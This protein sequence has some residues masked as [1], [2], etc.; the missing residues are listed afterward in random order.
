VAFGFD[1]ADFSEDLVFL[2]NPSALP[3]LI[4]GNFYKDHRD[5][6]TYPTA[7]SLLPFSLHP[8]TQAVLLL[9]DKRL[10]P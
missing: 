9:F 1:K 6:T 3:P 4:K 7:F 10:T 2:K 8:E 5:R